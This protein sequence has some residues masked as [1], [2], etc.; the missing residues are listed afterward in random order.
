[1]HG[2]D[3]GLLPLA[4]SPIISRVIARARPQVARLILNANGDPARFSGLALDIAADPVPGFPGPLAGLLAAMRWAEAHDPHLTHI[5]TF[6]ADTPF[7]PLDLVVRLDA[8]L[9]ETP[10]AIIAVARSPTGIQPVFALVP[11]ALA[12]RLA[13][14]LVSGTARRVLAWLQ[15]SPVAHADFVDAGGG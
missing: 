13:A 2:L 8:A 3:K 14:D 15:Q 12:D 6:A 7:L 4:G 9:A 5:A 11:V 1:M 10:G